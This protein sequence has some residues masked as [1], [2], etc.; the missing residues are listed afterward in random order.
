MKCIPL[1][2]FG[3]INREG[4]NPLPDPVP[5]HGVSAGI[6]GEGCFDVAVGWMGGTACVPR[7]D[8]PERRFQAV[9]GPLQGCS[10]KGSEKGLWH[11]FQFL[12]L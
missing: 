8:S 7:I 4:G 9:G 2:L 3:W 1:E 10:S 6:G 12:Q 11:L 5:R